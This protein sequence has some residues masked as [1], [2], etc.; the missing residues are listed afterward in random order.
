MSV[1]TI[2]RV[3]WDLQ[4]SDEK[5]ALYREQPNE[6]LNQY[7]LTTDEHSLLSDM[8]IES[9]VSLGI[10]Q[11]L[12]SMTWQAI[13]GPQGIPEYMQRLNSIKS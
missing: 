1:Y 5:A 8:D 7:N 3:L 11:M 10:D 4:D 13:N 2:E 9:M 6:I 12:M